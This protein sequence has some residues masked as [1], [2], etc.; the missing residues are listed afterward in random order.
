MSIL[1]DSSTRLVVQGI[2]G[3]EGSF[4]TR[5]C[6][7]YGTKVVASMTPGRGG[8]TAQE[9]DFAGLR[10]DPE[11]GPRFQKLVEEEAS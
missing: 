10:A 9:K 1:V 11:F 4:Q 2:S 8:E 7:G 3:R 5:R 6:I